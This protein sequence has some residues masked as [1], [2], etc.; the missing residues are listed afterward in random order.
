MENLY[1]ID[2]NNT[3]GWFTD[4]IGKTVLDS[5][6]A[7]FENKFNMMLCSISENSNPKTNPILKGE[8]FYT[9]RVSI[10]NKQHVLIRVSSD[11]IRILFHDLFGSNYPIFDLEK[12]TDLEQRI[13]NS[14]MEFI[15]K[16]FEQFLISDEKVA[17]IDPKNKGELTL[18]FL[19]KSKNMSAGKLCI[20]IPAN[21]LKPVPIKKNSSFSYDDFINNYSTVDIIAGYAK[22]SLEDLA[23]LDKDD[24]IVLEKSTI[25]NMTL[26][27]PFIT[28]SFRVNPNPAIMLDFDE[29][30]SED[31]E[32]E[33]EYKE[34]YKEE[35]MPDNKSVW[36]D[37]QIEVNAEFQKVKMS[38]GDLKQISKDMVIDLG[39]IMNNEISLLVENK[40][41]AKGEL[42]II[43]DKY[44]VKVK[45]VIANDRK[46]EAKA[47]G[48]P[49][50]GPAPEAKQEG[51]K[52][53]PPKPISGSKP[54]AAKDSK[55]DFDYSNFEE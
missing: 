37:I 14:A 10:K 11:F 34:E 7:F 26:K 23:N 2:L 46:Q 55:E 53:P 38:L 50:S 24:I 47:Q 41:V 28:R 16:D 8:L 22:L 33:N 20:T 51:P 45:E 36:D 39:P 19:V 21:R 27:T 9:C 40:I 1:K 25:Q 48:A 44:G 31:I 29:D 12:L 43:N 13:I 54:A 3:Y 15:T 32:I 35:I 42:V 5:A 52:G 49:A 18:V 6:S 30:D 17:E 4:T